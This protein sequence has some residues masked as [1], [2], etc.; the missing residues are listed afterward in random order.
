VLEVINKRDGTSFTPED[1]R[2]LEVVANQ[3][4]IAIENAR[5]LERTV[6][7]ER[8][9][10][11][12]RMAASVIHDLKNPMSVVRGFAELLGSAKL[13]AEKR[14]QFS[15]MILEEVDRFVGMTQ[16]LLDYSR[17]DLDLR[18][19]EI[20]LGDW[21]E[22]IARFL[23]DDLS[24]SGVEVVLDL[25]YAGP[26]AID[27]DR[28]RRVL[29]NIASNAKDAM[30]EGGIFTIATRCDGDLWELELRDTGSGIPAELRTKIFE[31]FFTSGREYGTG[32]GLA[33]VREIVE[34]HGGTIQLKN[35]ESDTKLDA[36]TGTAFLIR[37][38]LAPPPVQTSGQSGA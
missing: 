33:I 35:F 8:L 21:L 38:P 34:G 17:G 29:T 12:G 10:V 19:A 32:L 7:S 11:I 24:R 1:A 15:N 27:G 37:M 6:Q 22:D 18:S 30:T 20:S 16:E 26:V 36:T 14:S 2:L 28:M 9:S 31:P 4:A 13:D 23:Q 3:A 25:G 5:L